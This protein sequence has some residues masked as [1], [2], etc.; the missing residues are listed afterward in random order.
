MTSRFREELARLGGGRPTD[1]RRSAAVD[2]AVVATVATAGRAVFF[3]GLTVLLGLFGLLLFEFMVLRSVGIAGAIVVGLAALG[4]DAAAGRSGA[5]GP[6]VDRFVDPDARQRAPRSATRRSGRRWAW[7]A[8]RVMDRPWL[9]F[10]PTLGCSC[11][12]ACRSCTS[13]STHRTPRSCRPSA[14]TEAYDLLASDVRRGR[15]RAARPGRSGPAVPPP[16][17]GTSAALYDSRRLAADP[18][19]GASTGSWTSTLAC[20]SPN[21]SS[22]CGDRGP[23]DRF[24]AN[25]LR[26]DDQRRPDGVHC[27]HPTGP[28][29]RGPCAGRGTARP[30]SVPGAA[31]RH[32]RAR[33][34]RRRRGERR[35]RSHRGRL[36]AH[37]P[38]HLR[39][40]LPRPL[41]AVALGRAAAQ[42]A[43]HEH[44]SRSW[45]A[46]APWSGSSR[47]AT[48][49]RCSAS[50]RSASS[51]RRCR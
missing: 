18:G 49:R 23:A 21:T 7:L 9:V 34:W 4:A 5:L 25:A 1:G 28:T 46:S 8:E 13:A 33:R 42:G 41:P 2:A 20:R 12:S 17:P 10:L 30:D 47:T 39:D 29:A 43:G 50:R 51:R 38:V 14:L 45:P 24:A 27:R 15:V 32:D 19:S 37:G 31:G 3:S 16:T 44:A 48:C 11:C 6:R 22:L 35:R 36:P 40:H 26:G